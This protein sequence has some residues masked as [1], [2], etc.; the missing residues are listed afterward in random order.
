MAAPSNAI[1][2]RLAA[3]EQAAT[4]AQRKAEI[5]AQ[6]GVGAMGPVWEGETGEAVK[7]RLQGTFI[8]MVDGSW[9]YIP[10]TSGAAILKSFAGASD[11]ERVGK[12]KISRDGTESGS[13]VDKDQIA[14][15]AKSAWIGVASVAQEQGAQAQGLRVGGVPVTIRPHAHASQFD[16]VVIT[17]SGQEGSP[18][19]VSVE[20][21]ILGLHD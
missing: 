14:S 3:L 7:K 10:V 17:I 6:G 8:Q 18:V 11:N 16:K 12:I 2:T 5:T 4:E 9:G 21:P 1:S 15:V 20:A 13:Y 19:S